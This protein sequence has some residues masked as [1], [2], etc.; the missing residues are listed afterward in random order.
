ML[1]R[2]SLQLNGL[3]GIKF[4]ATQSASSD[5]NTLDDYE[6][7]T[8]TPTIT[9]STSNPTGITY[10]RQQGV[11]IKIGTFV[12]LSFN[13]Y[14]T[15]ITNGSGFIRISNFPFTAASLNEADRSG[16][17]INY[18]SGFTST[19]CPTG[20]IVLNGQNSI[21]L[22]TSNSADARDGRTTYCTNTG[23]SVNLYGTIM[24]RASA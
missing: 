15:A 16:M 1:F 2:S 14:I 8:W 3:Q 22:I 11:Y 6:E 9:Q 24:Y 19:S 12:Y 7:G 10:N 4:Q 17:T 20:G 23:T 21:E 13:L 18:C 5:A